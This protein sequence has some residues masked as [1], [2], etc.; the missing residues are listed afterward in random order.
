MRNLRPIVFYL[1]GC[2]LLVL[3]GCFG[4]NAQV[5][6]D[7]F[8]RLPEVKKTKPLGAPVTKGVV[9]VKA[10]RSDGLHRERTML[11][12]EH[13]QPLE[14]H[15]Y[16]Y[17]HW[18]NTP[19]RL[20]QE[21][22]LDYLGKIGFASDVIRYRPGM[23]VDAVLKGRLLRFER[24]LNASGIQV[25]VS[26]ELSY[27]PKAKQLQKGFH[28]EYTVT[29]DAQGTSIHDTAKT[30]GAALQQIYQ[31]FIKDITETL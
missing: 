11:Y 5:P 26:I 27:D 4:G 12:I 29:L 25:I 31:S 1:A 19:A 22:M 23:K 13:D 6:Q 21:N 8:Y 30:F 7:H 28:K 16:H 24:L 3:T 15:R 17:H 9:G 18:T 10:L 14:I 2:S 20:I